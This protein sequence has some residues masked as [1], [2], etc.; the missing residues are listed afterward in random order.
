MELFQDLGNKPLVMIRF[1]PDEYLNDKN[2]MVKSCWINRSGL[3]AIN[4]NKKKEWQDRLTTLKNNLNY[5]LD[6]EPQKD[7]QIEYLYY[8]IQKNNNICDDDII[9]A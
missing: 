7:V 9:I 6:N 1:N 4:N 8:D 2:E 3:M 5:Y